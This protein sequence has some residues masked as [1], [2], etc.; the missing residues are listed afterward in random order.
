MRQRHAGG[1]AEEF[2]AGRRSSSWRSTI[3]SSGVLVV[4]V[5]GTRA[6]PKWV[7]TGGFSKTSDVR[8]GTRV[9]RLFYS[10]RPEYGYRQKDRL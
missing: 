5:A 2:A 8:G 4:P 9:P 1:A 10:V 7:V 6:R 3:A